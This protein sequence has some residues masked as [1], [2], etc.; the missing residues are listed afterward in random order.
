MAQEE[1]KQ[2]EYTR[3]WQKKEPLVAR[4]QGEVLRLT[5]NQR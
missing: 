2:R 3:N 1:A 4:K 5:K